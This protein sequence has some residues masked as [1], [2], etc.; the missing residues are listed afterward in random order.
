MCSKKGSH[1]FDSGEAFFDGGWHEFRRHQIERV[2]RHDSRTLQIAGFADVEGG[3]E[4]DGVDL[5]V[6]RAGEFDERA[7]VAACEVGCVDICHRPLQPD[8]L[9][10][11]HPHGGENRSVYGLIGLIVCKLKADGVA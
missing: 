10:D 4:V 3:V 5:A 7:A 11:Q 1:D 8:A 2:F 6:V 9:T